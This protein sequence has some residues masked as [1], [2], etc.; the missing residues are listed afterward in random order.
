MGAEEW[1]EWQSFVS[2]VSVHYLEIPLL[3]NLHG[4]IEPSV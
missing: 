2:T 1:L 3:K 4:F